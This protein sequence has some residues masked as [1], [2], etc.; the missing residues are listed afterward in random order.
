MN[1]G[2]KGVMGGGGGERPKPGVCGVL[3][4]YEH[5]KFAGPDV[6]NLLENVY[7]EF[8]ESCMIPKSLK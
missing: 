4:N 7:Q 2:I 3:I 8:F 1:T 6:W 5:V